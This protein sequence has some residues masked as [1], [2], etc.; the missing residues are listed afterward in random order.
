MELHNGTLNAL[1][2]TLGSKNELLGWNMYTQKSGVIMVK[3]RFGEHSGSK[4][5]LLDDQNHLPDV[6]FRKITENQGKRNHLRAKTFRENQPTKRKRQYSPPELTRDEHFSKPGPNLSESFANV[7]V[8]QED[9]SPSTTHSPDVQCSP[10]RD[11]L[12]DDSSDVVSCV[13]NCRDSINSQQNQTSLTEP[14]ID[15]EKF[16]DLVSSD[17]ESD[18]SVSTLY[19]ENNICEKWR[20]KCDN[21][22]CNYG[23]YEPNDRPGPDI[24]IC[25]R[26]DYKICFECISYKKRHFRHRKHLNYYHFAPSGT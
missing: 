24:H 20:F 8:I 12:C 18:S 5:E 4:G 9:L 6:A 15:T 26:C 2:E 21:R 23:P 10:D 19:D 13:A 11:S 14:E 7:S 3:I 16:Q 17:C 1:L 25:N 22:G